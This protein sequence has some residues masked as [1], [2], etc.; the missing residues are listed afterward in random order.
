VR[1]AA[2]ADG[3]ATL[4]PVKVVPNASRTRFAGAHG[5]G[6]KIQVAAPPERGRA[7]E[8]VCEVLAE[9]LGVPARDVT[10]VR[11]HTSPAKTLRVL[12]LAPDEVARRL[13]P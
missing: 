13:V 8:A 2:S 12:G 7:N 1:L 5:D 9:A 4:V 6:V 11:G 3:R 10:V